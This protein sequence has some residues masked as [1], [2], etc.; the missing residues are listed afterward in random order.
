MTNPFDDDSGTF[1]VLINKAGQHSLWPAQLRVPAGWT[2]VHGPDGRQRCIH[3]VD[4]HWPDIRVIGPDETENC[5]EVVHRRF[6]RQ[7]ERTPDAVAV[8]SGDARLTYRELDERSNRLANHLLELGV[9]TEDPVAVLIDRSIELIVATLAVLKAGCYY[10]P[11]HTAHPPARMQWMMDQAGRPVLLTDEGWRVRGIP[12][13]GEV[14]VVDSDDRWQAAPATDPAVNV[15]SHRLAYVM[16]TSGSTGEPKGVAVTHRDV[17]GLAFDSAWDPANHERVLMLAPYA[18]DPSTYELWVPLLHG[19]R[20]VVAP[21]GELE[22]DTIR[23]LAHDQQITGLNLAAGLFRL[24]AEEIPEALAGVREVVTGGDV[25]SLTAVGRVLETNPAAVV[26]I[27]YGPTEVTLAATQLAITALDQV[28]ARV[29]IGRPMDHMRV[30]VLDH[31]LT[32][33]PDGELGEIYIAGLGVARGYI[34]KPGMTAE[35]F[36]ADPF[37]GDGQRMYRTGDLGRRTADGQLDFAGR[38]DDQVKIRDFRV[39]PAEVEAALACQPGVAQAVVVPRR[40]QAGDTRLAAFLVPEAGTLDVSRVRAAAAAT[41]PAYLVPTEFTVVDQLPLTPNHKIDRAALLALEPTQ[42][43]SPST[44]PLTAEQDVLCRLFA[45]TLG[46][47]RV[48]PRDNFFDLGGQSILGM[49]LIS[50]IETA[51][52]AR[53]AIADLFNAPTVAEIAKLIPARRE[54][55]A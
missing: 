9:S 41:L 18:F 6:T 37:T 1:V 24:V 3:Y 17:L 28:S 39:E 33:V 38:T 31:S 10:L 52:G 46:C 55:A 29:P 11:L 45:E 27:L 21:P 15:H 13:A 7:A 54:G 22:L 20:L 50:R 42:S 47:P 12:E 51:L 2:A 4:A 53:L 34:G 36:V 8:V 49:R 23:R 16:H 19:G 35:R 44:Q 14:V 32:P 5:S 25:V 43:T 48:D 26:R 30:H 40:V